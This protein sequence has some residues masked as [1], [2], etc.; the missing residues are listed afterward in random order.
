MG[1]AGALSPTRSASRRCA[2]LR[3]M[4][5][6]ILTNADVS[7]VFEEPQGV[8][9][10]WRRVDAPADVAAALAVLAAER[11]EAS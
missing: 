1:A 6:P 3:G 9:A 10:L 4:F 5:K 11:A 2:A 8:P 7:L